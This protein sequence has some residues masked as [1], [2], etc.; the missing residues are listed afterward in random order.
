MIDSK[1]LRVERVFPNSFLQGRD[2]T[3]FGYVF[4]GLVEEMKMRIC[5]CFVESQATFVMNRELYKLF[6]S[7]APINKGPYWNGIYIKEDLTPEYVSWD[8]DEKTEGR[9]LLEYRVPIYIP[10]ELTERRSAMPP[11]SIINGFFADNK[12]YYTRTPNLKIKKVIFNDPATIVMWNDGTK[13]VVKCRVGDIFDAEK[14]I[15]KKFIGLKDFYKAFNPAFDKWLS[16]L[17]VDDPLK[18]P[19]GRGEIE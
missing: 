2:Y 9:I 16:E 14:G 18:D 4:D 11:E 19:W 6:L 17:T 7:V 5:G 1:V 12:L 13:T 10:F 15:A 8:K 3:W